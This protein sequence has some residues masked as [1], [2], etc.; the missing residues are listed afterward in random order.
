MQQSTFADLG[1]SKAV[2]NALRARDIELPFA[3]QKLVVPDAL[4]GHDVLA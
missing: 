3:V 4:A 2:A 1:V